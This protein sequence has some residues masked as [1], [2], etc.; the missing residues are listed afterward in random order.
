MRAVSSV[1]NAAGL[2]KKNFMGK[3]TED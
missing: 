3:I 1:I 2:F